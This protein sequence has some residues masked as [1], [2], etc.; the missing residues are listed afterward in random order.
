MK[1]Y[2]FKELYD[3]IHR[4]E[5]WL[6]LAWLDIKLKYK[7]TRL[8]P[9][10]MVLFSFISVVCLALLGSLLFKVRFGDFFPYLASGMLIWTYISAMIS[11]ACS[12][13]MAQ[14]NL[15]KN[16]NVPLL[17]FGLRMFAK[18]TIVFMHSLVLMLFII[19]FYKIPI[20]VNL[21]I[22]LPALFLFMVTALSISIIIGFLSTRFR[23]IQ[24]LIQ[25]TLGLLAFMT[26]IMWK[27]DMLGDKAFLVNFNP[28]THYIAIMRAP[29]LGQAPTKVNILMSMLITG[30]LFLLASA[31]FSKYR[32]RVVHW[33]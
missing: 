9:M 28:L 12:L 3:C 18:N 23:D 30:L 26:P 14:T 15:I 6:Y 2:F 16:T 17:T 5:M 29:L 33:L 11:E 10:W 31:L 27:P 24:Q 13:Y 7:R 1:S 25:A 20:T 8:G 21:L 4:H 22:L 32:K 19:L